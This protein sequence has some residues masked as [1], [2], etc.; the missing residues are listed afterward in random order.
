MDEV[1]MALGNLGIGVRTIHVK[2]QLVSMDKVHPVVNSL[3][4]ARCRGGDDTKEP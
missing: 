3:L 4:P 2:L 1:D